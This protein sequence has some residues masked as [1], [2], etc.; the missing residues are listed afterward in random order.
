MARGRNGNRQGVEADFRKL[1]EASRRNKGGGDCHACGEIAEG[2]LRFG[3]YWRR[4]TFCW[5]SGWNSGGFSE[6]S[7]LFN[8]VGAL[9]LE[10]GESD[11]GWSSVTF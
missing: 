10:K 7:A 3:A 1:A 5:T 11:S 2:F 6:I 4:R 8:K 9:V